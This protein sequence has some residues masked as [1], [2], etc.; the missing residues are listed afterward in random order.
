MARQHMT[1]TDRSRR[2]GR[3][4]AQF[5]PVVWILVL[6]ASWLVIVEWQTLPDW[7]N[8]ALAALP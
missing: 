3:N 5:A 6:L 8:A 7:A 1:D 2:S 4:H